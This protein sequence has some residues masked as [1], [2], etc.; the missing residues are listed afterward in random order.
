MKELVFL[1]GHKGAGQ[2]TLLAVFASLLRKKVICSADVSAGARPPILSPQLKE[3]HAFEGGG[4]WFVSDTRFGPMMHFS[5]N[6]AQV[7]DAAVVTLIRQEGRRLAKAR[8]VDLLLTDG[9]PVPDCPVTAAAGGATA[10]LMLV[11]PTGSGRRD[12]ERTADLCASSGIPAMVCVNRFDLDL[13]LTRTIEADADRRKISRA[14]RIPFDPAFAEAA[15]AG[16]TILE[17]DRDSKGCSGA[18]DVCRRVI[19]ELE[20]LYG[21]PIHD[22]FTTGLRSRLGSVGFDLTWQ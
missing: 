12:W 18:M 11:E 4:E 3:R 17:Y 22:W 15:A 5:R 16:K 21:N 1:S 14:G 6:G 7:D 13:E 10:V 20:F 8:G 2:T 9:P 19:L